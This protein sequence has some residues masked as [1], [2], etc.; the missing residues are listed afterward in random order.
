MESWQKTGLAALGA[1][2]A[3]AGAIT[4]YYRLNLS[5]NLP[6]SKP[7]AGSWTKQSLQSDQVKDGIDGFN[8]HFEHERQPGTGAG[9]DSYR[10]AMDT[11]TFVDTFYNLVTDFYEY[12]WCALF[13]FPWFHNIP[14]IFLCNWILYLF[15]CLCLYVCIESTFPFLVLVSVSSIIR[16]QSFHFAPRKRGESFNRSLERHEQRIGDEVGLKAG[17]HGIDVGAG[18]G[19]PLRVIAQHSKAKMTGITINEYQ[20][21]RAEEHNK[22]M[23]LSEQCHVVQGSF[24]EMP[25]EQNTFDA[26]VCIE[27]ACHSPVLRDIYQQVYNVLKPGAK[28][29]SYE[30]LTTDKYDPSNQQHVD[31]VADINEGNALPGIRTIEDVKKAAEEVGFQV[32]KCEDVAQ[33]AEI[34]WQRAMRSARMSAYITHAMTWVMEKVGWAPK[35]TLAVHELLLKAAI[36][37]ERAGDWGIFTP[38]YLVVLQKPS[39]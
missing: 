19:G 9:F 27:S 33:E 32:V 21:Q 7:K 39:Q 1:A 29:A 12:G 22:R 20:V 36:A 2:T 13:C 15:L 16:G 24:L 23:G 26:G 28:F 5:G 18:V 38:M 17:M 25:F 35:G 34:P 8:K 4:V 37:L 3:A 10:K 6:G 30:W 14:F 11:P 31:T